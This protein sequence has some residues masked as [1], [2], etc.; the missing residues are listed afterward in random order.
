MNKAFLKKSFVIAILLSSCY[1]P[2]QWYSQNSKTTSY[3]NSVFFI[4][5]TTGWACGFEIVLKTTNCGNTW[6]NAF[7][8]GNNRSIYF[9]DVNTGFICGDNGRLYR[10]VNGGQDWDPINTGVTVILNQVSFLNEN[11]GLLVGNNR[12]ILKSTDSGLNWYNILNIN[13]T[14]NFLS[15]KILN[16]NYIIASGTESSLYTSTNSGNHWDTL[17]FGMP[18]PLLTIE[19]INENT[20]W[21]SGCCGMFLKTTNAGNNWTPEVY[22]TPGYSIYSMKFVNENMGWIVGDAGYILRTTDGGTRWDSLNSNTHK[23]LHGLSMVNGDTGFAVG[24]NGLILRTTNGG[25]SGFPIGINQISS[26]TPDGF[27]L[28]QNY[29]NPFNPKTIIEYQVSVLAQV[30]L[31]VYDILGNEIK[32]LVNKKQNGGSYRVEF[33]G[34]GYPTGIYFYRIKIQSNN[35]TSGGFQQVRKM[36]LIK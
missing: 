22:L 30:E 24:Y 13:S 2:A 35:I 15:A 34:N 23:D 19:F 26:E 17:S 21:V 7:L 31:K 14:L 6:T 25:G 1:S 16:T 5:Q 32:T 18:N 29:P 3:L 27:H 11:F 8:S 12:T 28:Y 36:I 10:T 20:G 33:E 4:N 9:L